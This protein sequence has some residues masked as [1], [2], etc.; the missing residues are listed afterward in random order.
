MIRQRFD[1]GIGQ[2]LGDLVHHS[3]RTV[4]AFA[5]A[6][7]L[8]LRA[9]VR[10]ALAADHRIGRVVGRQAFA[11]FAVT[12]DAWRDVPARIALQEQIPSNRIISASVAMHLVL[13]GEISRDIGCLGIVDR[14]G[15]RAHDLVLA[16]PGLEIVELLCNILGVLSAEIG[17]QVL[18]AEAD[19]AVTSLTELR[20]D[21][22]GGRIA[23]ADTLLDV[24]GRFSGKSCGACE[25]GGRNHRDNEAVLNALH[26]DVFQCQY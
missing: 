24:I 17:D 26:G 2:G 9:Q 12:A 8:Q 11:V 19:F 25:Q 5:A 6:P 21:L 3:A 16:R 15:H 22:A 20:P 4:A 14:P 13:A 1:L 7:M 10:L 18:H 23:S